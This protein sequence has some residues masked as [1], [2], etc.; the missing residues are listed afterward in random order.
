MSTTTKTVARFGTYESRRAAAFVKGK[1]GYDQGFLPP[2]TSPIRYAK[3]APKAE[4]TASLSG[5]IKPVSENTSVYTNWKREVSERRRLYMQEHIQHEVTERPKKVT[6]DK[7]NMLRQRDIREGILAAPDSQ[8]EQLS[9]PS[10]EKTIADEYP[11]IDHNK[12][13]RDRQ[14]T[15]NRKKKEAFKNETVLHQFL[16]IHH[17]SAGYVTTLTG[18]DKLLETTIG[19][20]NYL[21]VVPKHTLTDLSNQPG[22]GAYSYGKVNQLESDID[23]EILGTAAGGRPGVSEVSRILSSSGSTT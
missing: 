22:H 11:L 1:S 8:A 4:L 6:K 20:A 23:D 2:R 13:A 14:R 9:L 7:A 18:L 17:N 16:T 19:S 12:A 5:K 10:I 15:L 21:D 3:P